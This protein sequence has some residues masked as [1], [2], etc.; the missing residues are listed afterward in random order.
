MH[1]S[2]GA[3][4]KVG[5]RVL[6]EAEVTELNGSDENYCCCSVKVVLPDQANKEKVMEHRPTISA[7]STKMLT[8]VGA[9]VTILAL[10]LTP[11]V[12]AC[13]G[14]RA[15]LRSRVQERRAVRASSCGG[16]S[17]Q[18]VQQV[19]TVRVQSFATGC[20]GAV[21]QPLLRRQRVVGCSSAVRQA[22][23]GC[24]SSQMAPAK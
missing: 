10:I 6:I 20:S 7:M 16:V 3:P 2:R 13:F 19:T 18:Q 22:V 17:V 23:S 24:S 21:R 5:D 1:D 12:D 14:Q 9:V 15:G 4:I 8:K 11:E